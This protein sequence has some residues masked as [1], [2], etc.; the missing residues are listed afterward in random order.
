MCGGCRCHNQLWCDT[1]QLVREKGLHAVL[2]LMLSI[3]NEL[4]RAAACH[5]H[6]LKHALQQP[7]AMATVDAYF[8]RL[9]RG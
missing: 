3:A 7:A 6:R 1:R 8:V 4:R 9:S 5:E 2:M